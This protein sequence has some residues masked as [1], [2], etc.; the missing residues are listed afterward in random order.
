MT[1]ILR[2]WHFTIGLILALPQF[3]LGLTGSILL[4]RRRPPHRP[5]VP[6]F[7]PH[8]TPPHDLFFFVHRLH[9]TFALGSL[10]RAL[11]ALSGI[12]LVALCVSGIPIA[13]RRL[14]TGPWRLQHWHGAVGL[15]TV[16]FLAAIAATGTA[17]AAGPIIGE[18][19]PMWMR[20]VHQGTDAPAIWRG[21]LFVL[22]FAPVFF[23]ITGLIMKAKHSA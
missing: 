19:A 16:I 14:R 12:G 4:F 6:P 13:L 18:R 21:A 3:V 10:G 11:V 20:A 7:G 2:R 8:H 23:A 5:G 9:E 17:I 15:V 22:G 1:W